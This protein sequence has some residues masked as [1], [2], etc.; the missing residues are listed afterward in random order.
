[1]VTDYMDYPEFDENIRSWIPHFIPD[2]RRLTEDQT[3]VE[4]VTPNRALLIKPRVI[5]NTGTR[6]NPRFENQIAGWIPLTNR[7]IPLRQNPPSTTEVVTIPMPSVVDEAE[8]AAGDYEIDSTGA[9]M[10]DFGNEYLESGVGSAVAKVGGWVWRNSLPLWLGWEAA[11]RWRDW[12]A[13]GEGYANIG[14]GGEVSSGY[15]TP[16]YVETSTGSGDISSE[17]IPFSFIIM[18]LRQVLAQFGVN[19]V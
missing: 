15:G 19:F 18:V 16:E 1:M 10:Y 6:S 11:N 13:P 5:A 14:G 7:N 4:S 2:N 17:D 12:T 9:A 3:A 8:M